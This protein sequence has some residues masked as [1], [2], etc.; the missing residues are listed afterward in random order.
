MRAQSRA[1][2]RNPCAIREDLLALCGSDA[3]ESFGDAR[4]DDDRVV[5]IEPVMRVGDAM[6]MAAFV[7]DA[8]SAYFEQ[9]DAGRGVDIG[10]ASA[11]Q[12]LVADLADERVEPV[13]VAEADAHEQVRAPQFVE[14]AGTRLEGFGID[15]GRDDRF[16]GDEIAAD[17][18]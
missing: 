9:R 16:H 1:R 15:A 17:L 7:H 13:V 3:D 12:A 2:D 14:V 5:G 8:L 4:G 18:R 10:L 6:R 11:H